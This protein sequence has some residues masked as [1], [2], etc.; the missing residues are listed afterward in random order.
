[1]RN[2]LQCGF[3]DKI[4]KQNTQIVNP[5]YRKSDFIAEAAFDM[6]HEMSI[7][8]NKKVDINYE[9][10]LKRVCSAG[11]NNIY[12][13]VQEDETLKKYSDGVEFLN[14]KRYKSNQKIM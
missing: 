3:Y 12:E 2:K 6:V 7:M 10:L 14:P 4:N 8:L 13:P 11:P 5:Q 9:Y 1:V